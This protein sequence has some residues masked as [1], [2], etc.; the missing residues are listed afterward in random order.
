MG[1]TRFDTSI[2]RSVTFTV[3]ANHIEFW[4][5]HD[6]EVWDEQGK[7]VMITLERIEEGWRISDVVYAYD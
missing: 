4:D 1:T 5:K 6:K 2:M 7:S 3:T